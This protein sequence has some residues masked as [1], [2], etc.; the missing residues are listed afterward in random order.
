M[1]YKLPLFSSV[2]VQ[3]KKNTVKS[4]EL[5]RIYNQYINF[6]FSRHTLYIICKTQVVFLNKICVGFFNP[7]LNLMYINIHMYCKC[8]L[9]ISP[10][11]KWVNVLYWGWIH[12]AHVGY[13][14]NYLGMNPSCPCRLQ[15]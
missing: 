14:A 9:L 5:M 13:K 12:P 4:R 10:L 3:A 7:F 11:N 6:K 1:K 2:A 15:G 8:T